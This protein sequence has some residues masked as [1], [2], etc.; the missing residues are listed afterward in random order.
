MTRYSNK[1]WEFVDIHYINF[2]IYVVGIPFD[3]III[4]RQTVHSSH[5]LYRY[6]GLTICRYCGGHSGTGHK[7]VRLNSVCEAPKRWGKEAIADVWNG[8]LPRGLGNWPLDS[9]I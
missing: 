8:K 4:G 6:R 7:M 9:H 1:K 2:K 5:R 3:N